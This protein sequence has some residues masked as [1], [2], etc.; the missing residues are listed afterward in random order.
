MQTRHWFAIEIK[1]LLSHLLGLNSHHS[2]CNSY[3]LSFTRKNLGANTKQLWQNNYPSKPGPKRKEV[4]SLQYNPSRHVTQT[5]SQN[6]QTNNIFFQLVA[7][8]IPAP[9]FVKSTIPNPQ[10]DARH[11]DHV[12][13]NVE[14]C[15]E[16][17]VR[18]YMC[19][20]AHNILSI[21]LILR[22]VWFMS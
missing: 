8:G 5:T 17:H 20:C 6:K 14:D 7:S 11:Q 15:K 19:A 1:G 3:S 22:R 12:R 21:L 4:H 16:W 13:M 10:T 2:L 9:F 18:I